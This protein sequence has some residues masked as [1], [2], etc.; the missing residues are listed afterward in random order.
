M[1]IVSGKSARLVGIQRGNCKCGTEVTSLSVE[2]DEMVGTILD[3]HVDGTVLAIP[4]M[5]AAE[6]LAHE[7]V[8][9]CD[10]CLRELYTQARKETD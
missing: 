4:Y 6:C 5:D 7:V 9:V 8:Y 1:P 3:A 10:A 2:L